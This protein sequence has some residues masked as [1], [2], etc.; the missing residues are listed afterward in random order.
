MADIIRDH[1]MPA[2]PKGMV[3]VHLGGGSDGAEANELAVAAA[4]RHTNKVHGTPFNKIV[5]VGF[6]NSHAGNTTG[7]LS[8]SATAA[9][10][11]G[12]PAFPWPK[13]QF[14]QLKYPLAQFEHENAEEERRCLD[15]FKNIIE[16]QRANGGAVGAVVVEP[17]SS[18]G[19]QIATPNFFKGI[20]AVCKNEG[21]PFI[22]DETKTGMSSTG[23]NWGHQWW[24]LGDDQAPDFVTFGGKSGL[25]GFYSTLA[26][27]L[28]DATTFSQ[29]LNMV[30][31]LHY[32]A[33]W[34]TIKQ[35]STQHW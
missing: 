10:P 5:A 35:D 24:Y 9:N 16:A 11:N 23:K 15:N 34:K 20:R 27:R 7:S 4:F 32:G 28:E 17:I 8:F 19:N 18:I 14:P 13:A 33:I 2:A 3:Q 6:D 25:G 26:H 1:V 22:V 30:S 12:L 31:L 29:N 21:V